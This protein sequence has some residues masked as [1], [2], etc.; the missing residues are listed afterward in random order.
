MN[1]SMHRRLDQIIGV[2][3]PPSENDTLEDLA[4]F[5][6]ELGLPLSQHILSNMASG[7]TFSES[8][9]DLISEVKGMPLDEAQELVQDGMKGTGD[10]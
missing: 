9:E 7:K 5:A 4:D 1:R 10:E 8:L 2:L 6:G 3:P